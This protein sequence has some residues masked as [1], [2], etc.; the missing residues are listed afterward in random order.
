MDI[1]TS[2]AKGS[3]S[4]ETLE[5]FDMKRYSKICKAIEDSVDRYTK[6][7]DMKGLKSDVWKTKVRVMETL[8]GSI[9]QDNPYKSMML[10]SL[11]KLFDSI[12][13]NPDKL[14]FFSENEKELFRKL[15]DL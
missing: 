2:F 4:D 6:Y 14:E 8:M 1:F 11:W 10:Y 7:R 5:D 12:E 15:D 9:F 3:L 13:V